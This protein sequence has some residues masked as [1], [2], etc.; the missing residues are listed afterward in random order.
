MV[1]VPSI[2][3]TVIGIIQPFVRFCSLLYV[4]LMTKYQTEGK[5]ENGVLVELI[6]HGGSARGISPHH[7]YCTVL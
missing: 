4:I 1:A 5:R 6:K 7:T 2:A 3:E